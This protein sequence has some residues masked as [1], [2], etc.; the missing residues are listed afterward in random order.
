MNFL[1]RWLAACLAA[2]LPL[3]VAQHA[4]AA[5]VVLFD[6]SH[7]QQFLVEA[8][9][10]LDLS[11]LAGLFAEQGAM[12]KT[13]TAPISDQVLQ[14][15]DVLII[16]GP[17]APIT[18]AEV[19]AVMKFVYHGG[20]LAVMAHIADPLMGL[21]PQMGIAMSSLA[22]AEQENIVGE[23][24]RDFLLKDLASH[25]LT[26]GLANFTIY[27]GWALLEKKKD[28]AV[29]ARTS[30]RA[31]VDLNQNGVLNPGDAMQ[32][33]A[34]VL[35]GRNGAGSFVVFGDDALFQNRFLKDGNLTL[36]R[37]LA[38]WFCGKEHAI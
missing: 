27:G 35:A 17:F 23:N 15:V 32:S 34:M 7:G 10:P 1:P 36:A 37:N 14:G 6:Q 22:V 31:W 20:R 3:L 38:A 28:I 24:G 8:N 2:L 25:P 4:K 13:S 9:R 11:G 21:L 26:V 33:F 12:V 16:S 18:P 30:H 29:I 5:P 19:L